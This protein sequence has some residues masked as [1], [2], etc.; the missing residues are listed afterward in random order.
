MKIT[1]PSYFDSFSCIAGACPDSCCK[2]WDVQVDPVS[3]KY[4]RSLPGALRMIRAASG[5]LSSRPRSTKSP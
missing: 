3:A 2:E 5:Q 4:Y 1:K